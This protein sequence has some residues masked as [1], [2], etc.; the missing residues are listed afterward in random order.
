MGKFYHIDLKQLME[1]E[2]L[3]R[4]RDETREIV[5][6]LWNGYADVV[7]YNSRYDNAVFISVPEELLKPDPSRGT[8]DPD[9]F[10]PY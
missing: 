2:K 3:V 5:L 6:R 7:R 9:P 4:E 1:V 10:L 8:S